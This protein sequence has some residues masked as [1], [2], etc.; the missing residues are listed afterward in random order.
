ML[1]KPHR[2]RMWHKNWKGRWS[3]KCLL[4]NDMEKFALFHIG[5]S[6]PSCQPFPYYTIL[7][8]PGTNV[9]CGRVRSL[10]KDLFCC[11]ERKVFSVQF[12]D[13]LTLVSNNHKSPHTANSSSALWQRFISRY[14]KRWTSLKPV[15]TTH[16]TFISIEFSVVWHKKTFYVDILEIA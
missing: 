16:S 2:F 13:S 9:H 15:V 1:Q 5:D 4:M 12:K 3:T 10:A 7:F 8:V 14:L 11:A 6:L